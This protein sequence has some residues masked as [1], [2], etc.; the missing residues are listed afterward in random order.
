MS[1]L[2]VAAGVLTPDVLLLW[3]HFIR[4][5]SLCDGHIEILRAWNESQPVQVQ[6]GLVLATP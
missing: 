2:S 3:N 5:R 4:Q 1:L 6:F